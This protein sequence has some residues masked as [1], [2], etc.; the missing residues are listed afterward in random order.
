MPLDLEFAQPLPSVCA[1]HGRPA[2]AWVSMRSVFYETAVHP[3]D[4]KLSFHAPHRYPPPSTVVDGDWPIC[5][6]C[7]GYR[8]RY[9]G[10][11]GLLA[12]VMVANL[13]AVVVVAR[14][15]HYD[16]LIP[17]LAL[18]V[19]PGSIPLGLLVMSWLYKK[20]DPRM[21]LRP[22]DD[23]RF[24]RVAV[25]PK[26]GAA[27][28]RVTTEPQGKPPAVQHYRLEHGRVVPDHSAQ[29]G[30]TGTGPYRMENGRVVPNYAVRPGDDR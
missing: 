21:T 15:V 24:L 16:P 8:R 26:F 22:I 3:R 20:G 25:H 28:H 18:G 29:G 2:V 11:A 12:I 14:I 7:S 6:L 5:D 10:L 13:I 27:V 17:P 1:A 9:R 30:Q 19:F 23:E 4:P